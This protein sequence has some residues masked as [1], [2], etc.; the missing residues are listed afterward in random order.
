MFT[1]MVK[2]DKGGGV[3]VLVVVVVVVVVLVVVVVVV[4]VVVI[5]KL[6]GLPK[7]WMA[8]HH[9]TSSNCILVMN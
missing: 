5:V 9:L 7:T 3:V 8:K 4:V 2:Q 1:I 6:L